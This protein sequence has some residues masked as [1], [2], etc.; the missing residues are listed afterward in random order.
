MAVTPRLGR[1][2]GR[3]QGPGTA[4]R[5]ARPRGFE[6]SAGKPRAA[7]EERAESLGVGDRIHWLGYVADRPTYLDALAAC[8]MFVFPS[9]AEGFPKVILDAMAV[10]LP[11]VAAPSGQL[12]PL[13]SRGLIEVASRDTA[14]LAAA[15]G[16]LAESPGRAR[17]LTTRGHALAAAHTRSAE[18]ERLLALWRAWWPDLAFD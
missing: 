6:G 2:S 4:P 15:I 10:G 16:R 18:A 9:P 5:R 14:A 12:R 7:L 1:T 3:R 11:V 17:D 8:D 13:A